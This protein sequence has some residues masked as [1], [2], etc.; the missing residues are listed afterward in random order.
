MPPGGLLFWLVRTLGWSG[1]GWSRRGLEGGPAPK[2]LPGKRSA[3]VVE[4]AHELGDQ[5]VI[6]IRGGTQGRIPPDPVLLEPRVPLCFR[7][8]T[9]ARLCCGASSW[10]WGTARR[11]CPRR[12]R[13]GPGGLRLNAGSRTVADHQ[14]IGSGRRCHHQPSCLPRA[15]APRSIPIS[16][17]CGSS[18]VRWV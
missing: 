13:V 2:W 11:A 10:P 14:G 12:L 17:P 6:S 18:V 15:S 16:E 8:G 5:H 7:S 3:C 1:V 4:L 9:R